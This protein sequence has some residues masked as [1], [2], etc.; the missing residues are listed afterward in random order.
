MISRC[1]RVAESTNSYSR[2]RGR[3]IK[4][5]DEW[6]E[7]IKNFHSWAMANGYDESLTI[8]RR[9]NDGDYEPSNCRWIPMSEQSKNM[10]RNRVITFEDKTMIMSDWAR[11]IGLKVGTLHVRLKKGWSIE[12]ALTFPLLNPSQSGA[13]RANAIY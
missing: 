9:N 2:Y 3:G 13:G 7:D 10:A 8:D 4:V 5:C 6:L 12:E 11:D 1:H